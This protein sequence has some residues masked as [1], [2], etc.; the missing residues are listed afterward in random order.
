M[1]L[2]LFGRISIDIL[3]CIS[4]ISKRILKTLALVLVLLILSIST[5][6]SIHYLSLPSV[7]TLAT[8]NP[9][10]T[11]F[12]ELYKRNESLLGNNP[13]IQWKWVPLEQISPFI[14]HA[15]IYTEDNGFMTHHGIEWDQLIMALKII[16]NQHRIVT[17]GSTITQQVAKN[18]YLSPDRTFSRKCRELLLAHELEKNLSKERIFEIYLNIVEWG[19]GIFGIEAASLHWY[20]CHAYELTPKQAISLAFALPNPHLRNPTNLS[21]RLTMY[22]NL[23]LLNFAQRG[24]I[25]HEEAVES[26]T[27][28]DE[29]LREEKEDEI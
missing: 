27:L 11:A 9:A 24:I 15:L 13:E 17:G 7:A 25:A 26:L 28:P 5:F 3:R 14:V 29:N 4:K 23:L 8:H 19:D 10:T 22:T 12:I 18:L 16:W 2:S 6:V 21:P 1:Q 20:Q